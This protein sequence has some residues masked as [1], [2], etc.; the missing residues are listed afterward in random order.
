MRT[1][2]INLCG[3]IMAEA[4]AH[5]L[6]IREGRQESPFAITASSLQRD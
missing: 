3:S 6:S 1:Q 4:R 5:R 2:A